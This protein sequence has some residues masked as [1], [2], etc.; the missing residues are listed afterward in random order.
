[1]STED[2]TSSKGGG[3]P[4]EVQG[5]G[6]RIRRRYK[7]TSIQ[8]SLRSEKGQQPSGPIVAYEG[9]AVVE[10]I[11]VEEYFEETPTTAEP[12]SKRGMPIKA[13]LFVV[14]MVFFFSKTEPGSKLV[15]SVF[16]ALHVVDLVRVFLR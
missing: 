10:E 3:G 11:C 15:E 12:S 5:G 4:A 6:P 16:S 2:L 8:R 13:V 7:K 9:N 14:S 1:M